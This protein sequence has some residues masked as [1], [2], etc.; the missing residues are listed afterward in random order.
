VGEQ[1]KQ[2]HFTSAQTSEFSRRLRKETDL[3]REWVVEDYFDDKWY[4]GG[5]ELECCIVDENLDPAPQN[6]WLLDKLKR[7]Q[8]CEELAR[9]DIEFNTNPRCL[10]K[11]ATSAF[12]V[13]ISTLWCDAVA[14]ARPLGLQL[15]MIGILPTLTARS[16][17]PRYISEVA[18]YYALND[19]LL[20][21]RQGRPMHLD[22]LGNEHLSI[23]QYDVMLEA[24]GTSF[25]IHMQVP[26]KLAHLY[27]NASLLASA[28]MVALGANSPYFL[29]KDLWDETRIPIFEQSVES[30][31]FAGA[32][33]GPVRRCS[34]GSGFLRQSITECFDENVAHFPPLLPVL[35]DDP[36]ESLKHLRLHNGTIWRW[37][38]PIIGF[39]AF[40]RSHIRIEQRILPSGPTL[41]DS[42]ANAAFYFGLCHAIVKEG[43]AEKPEISFSQAKDNFYKSARASFN[44]RC[45]WLDGKAYEVDRLI[46]E[47]LIPKAREGLYALK[48]DGVEIDRWLGIIEQRVAVKQN[49]SVWQR[50]YCHKYGVD[51]RRML[52]A[53][54]DHQMTDTPVHLWEV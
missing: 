48:L 39:D 50:K 17:S 45:L 22:I 34:F 12:H 18:R 20:R 8:V 41:T 25:Q 46:A 21:H 44:A 42:I 19:Q 51:L 6:R 54:K 38:R 29:G 10:E 11:G 14:R 9:F 1:I 5:F 28:P 23:E 13:D 49:G 26:P 37:I 4:Q 53:Y 2:L 7:V 32:S 16:L 40:G 47:I 30:G 3:L 52:G 24:A 27:Y 31:G 35:S 33:R 15:V 36:L 43:R